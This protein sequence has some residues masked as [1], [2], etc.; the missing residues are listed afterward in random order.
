MSSSSS[1]L[2]QWLLLRAVSQRM[3]KLA[4]ENKWDELV[5]GEIEY[6]QLVETL[7]QQ[8]ITLEDVCANQIKEILMIVINN[9]NEVKRLLNIRMEELKTLIKNGVQQKSITSAYSNLSG[10]LLIPDAPVAPQ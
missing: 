3:L 7:A 10:V 4:T 9:E 8:I 2:Q 6:V 5:V 1:S